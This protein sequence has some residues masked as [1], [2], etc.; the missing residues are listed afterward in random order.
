M[1]DQPGACAVVCYG[2]VS[3]VTKE[4]MTAFMKYI[5]RFSAEWQATFA[6]TISKTTSKQS[7]AFSNAEFSKWVAANQDLL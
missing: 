4:T 6:I 2:A 7:I 3:K 1:P 5:N